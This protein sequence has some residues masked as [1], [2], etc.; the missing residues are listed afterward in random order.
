MPPYD[1]VLIMNTSLEDP[2]AIAQE[3][4]IAASCNDVWQVLSDLAAHNSW[5]VAF[6]VEAAPTP[7]QPGAQVRICAAPDTD[8]ARVFTA[9]ILDVV[10]PTLLSWRGGQ[11]GVFE[12]IHRFELYELEPQQTRL[13]NREIF[14]G[15]MAAEVLQ[16]S[17]AALTAEFDVFNQAL[18]RNIESVYG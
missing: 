7:L 10:A 13:V 4:D 12:G 16:M 14:S 5:N 18:K 8:Q 9:E 1:H 15:E 6:H 2:L 17:R 11:P 3:I